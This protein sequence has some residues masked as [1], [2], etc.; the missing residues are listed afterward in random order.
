[1][2]LGE[3]KVIALQKMQAAGDDHLSRS[4]DSEPYIDRMRAP[5]NEALLLIATAARPYRPRSSNSPAAAAAG[6]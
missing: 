2:T 4:R 6:P 1:M 3:L 5:V